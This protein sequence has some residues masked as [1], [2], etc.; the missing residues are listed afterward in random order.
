ML[1]TDSNTEWLFGGSFDPIHKG[2]VAI[3]NRLRQLASDWPIRLLPCAIPALKKPNSATFEQRIEMLNLIS[4]NIPKLVIDSREGKRS[5]PSYTIDTLKSLRY[6]YPN[7]RFVL[8]IGDDNLADL[9]RWQQSEQLSQF[10]HCM[11]IDRPGYLVD[12]FEEIMKA[13]HFQS[14][15]RWQ[16]FSSSSHGKYFRL[17]DIEQDISST[18][19]RENTKAKR[20]QNKTIERKQNRLLPSEVENYIQTHSIYR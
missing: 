19:I 17:Q 4:A 3:I 10:C 14:V 20:N 2:H 8:V 1:M 18:Q 15:E 7:R 16:Q 5:G 11:V 13:I 6:D 9:T 12:D